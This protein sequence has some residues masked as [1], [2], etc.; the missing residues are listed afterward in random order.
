MTNGRSDETAQCALFNPA[1]HK[2]HITSPTVKQDA[3]GYLY[4]SGHANKENRS[5]GIGKYWD[6]GGDI[7]IGG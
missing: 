2:Y 3:P 5:H 6:D 1:N 7:F 4:Y